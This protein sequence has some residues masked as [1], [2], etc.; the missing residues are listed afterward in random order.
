MNLNDLITPESI[1]CPLKANSKKHALQALSALAGDVTGFDERDIFETLVMRERLG[2]T[3]LGRGVAI[4]H[5][6]VE[7]LDR[8]TGFFAR[9]DPAIDFDASDDAPVDLIFVLLAPEGSGAAHLK[10]LAR[11]SRVLR[12]QE[13]V[14]RL[15]TANDAEAA[16][17]VLSQSERSQAA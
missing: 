12:S 9:T 16:H 14:A 5:G 10:A 15:R 8:M 4:P 1:L 17:A 2:S 13:S 7:G 3:G 6:K 11:V